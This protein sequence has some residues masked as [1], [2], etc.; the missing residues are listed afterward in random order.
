MVIII[1]I[2]AQRYIVRG[3]DEIM[4]RRSGGEWRGKKIPSSILDLSLD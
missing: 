4:G 2:Q 3:G 1:M